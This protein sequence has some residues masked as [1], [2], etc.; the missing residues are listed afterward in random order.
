M[1]PVPKR[2]KEKR[3]VICAC[4]SGVQPAAILPARRRQRGQWRHLIF[5]GLLIV[6]LACSPPITYAN[7]WTQTYGSSSTLKALGHPCV[8]TYNPSPVLKLAN[9][10]LQPAISEEMREVP[11]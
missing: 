6:L 3:N 7:S 8:W 4:V 9:V 5:L 11:D 1:T 10:T 2:L